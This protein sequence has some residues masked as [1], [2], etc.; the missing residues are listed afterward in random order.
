MSYRCSRARRDFES[1][2]RKAKE[3]MVTLSGFAKKN[4]IGASLLGVYFVF[5]YSQLEVYI[6]SFVEDCVDTLNATQPN[7][8]KWPNLMLG[9][10]L[11]GCEEL[12]AAYRKFNQDEDERAIL[13]KLSEVARRIQLWGQGKVKPDESD[14][15]KFLE[16][17]KYPSPRNL[18]HLFRRLGI[19]QIWAVIGRAGK[20]NGE[21]VL[22]SLNDL[23]TGVAHEG[24]MPPEFSLSDYRERLK[25]M[26]SFVAALDRGVSACF[27]PS[28]MPRRDWNAK[29][30]YE[31][32][33]N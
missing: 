17:R 27:C 4:G 7:I 16:K 13:N 19:D 21:L 28:V 22:T 31:N 3:E 1:Q 20:M 9:F 14:A 26:R 15:A 11:H 23:R 2:L 30:C 29:M 10:H 8:E 5:A 24:R 18:P 32:V 12:G 25:Q 6:K 33:A